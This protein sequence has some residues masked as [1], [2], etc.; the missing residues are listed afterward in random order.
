MKYCCE[1]CSKVLFDWQEGS[2]MIII[3]YRYDGED[4][5]TA[6][7]KDCYIDICEYI[8]GK[9][10]AETKPAKIKVQLDD[11][12]YMPE[13]AHAT[14]A[15]YDLRTRSDAVIMPGEAE[16]FDTGVHI[17]LPEGTAG[18]LKSK[19]GLNV[20]HGITS[21]GVIDCGYTGSIVAKL[22][23]HGHEPYRV[24]A[25]DKITQLVILPVA[26]LDLMQAD[27]LGDTER[28]ASGFGSSG[29]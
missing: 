11:G 17:E 18:F 20:K 1:I 16:C 25:G 5:K 3:Q 12:A 24:H 14:D 8:Y 15:G 4:H 23:N 10:V 2:E 9:K 7:C 21:E 28:G 13:K 6:L 26:Q 29:R 27:K 22:Y 19:S